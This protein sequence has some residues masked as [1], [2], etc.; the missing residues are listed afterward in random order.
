MQKKAAVRDVAIS[1][2]CNIT[3]KE[4]EKLEKHQGLKEELREIFG[5]K[6]PGG[7]KGDR[8]TQGCDPP[9]NREGESSRFQ[10]EDL[11]PRK[12]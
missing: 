6:G 3:K 11:S 9:P 8:S 5:S 1:S 7:A 4:H 2:D 10:D 12:N